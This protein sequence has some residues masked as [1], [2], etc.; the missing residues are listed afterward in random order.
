[1]VKDVNYYA[2]IFQKKYQRN[3][4]TKACAIKEWF[5]KVTP[6]SHLVEKA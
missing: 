1:M 3:G 6:S 5:D 4:D 2:D